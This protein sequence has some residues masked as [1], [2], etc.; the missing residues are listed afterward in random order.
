MV[1]PLVMRALSNPK[2]L[3]IR[4]KGDPIRPAKGVLWI[5]LVCA[6]FFGGI[7]AWM[8][9]FPNGTEE[10]WIFLMFSLFVIMGIGLIAWRIN[11]R[12]VIKEDHI[13]WRTIFRRTNIIPFSSI[14]EY[15]IRKR[16]GA[17][18]IYTNKKN[19]GFEPA[20]LDGG[21]ELAS[22][23]RKKARKKGTRGKKEALSCNRWFPGGGVH[24]PRERERDAV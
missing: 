7:I 13:V 1:F 20:F 10:W 2:R 6:L 8:W 14:K 17:I 11:H 3:H 9:L 5:G 15:A 12:I 21:Q 23:L 4:R 19:F 22:A 18:T 16:D 24:L